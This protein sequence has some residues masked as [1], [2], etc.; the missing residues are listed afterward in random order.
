MVAHDTMVTEKFWYLRK[1]ICLK[2][3]SRLFDRS[4]ARRIYVRINVLD[5]FKGTIFKAF[6]TKILTIFINHPI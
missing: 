3:D 2:L 4:R 1:I 6:E 5:R